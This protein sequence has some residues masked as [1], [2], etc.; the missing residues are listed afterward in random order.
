ME[1]SAL[2]TILRSKLAPIRKDRGHFFAYWAAAGAAGLSETDTPRQAVSAR[3]YFVMRSAGLAWVPTFA[4]PSFPSK[5][6]LCTQ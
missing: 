5:T 2:S 3:R 1:R 4:T 6:S